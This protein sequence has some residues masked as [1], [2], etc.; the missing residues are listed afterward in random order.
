MFEP[1]LTVEEAYSLWGL[2][3]VTFE[4]FKDWWNDA[5][6]YCQATREFISLHMFCAEADQ[7]WCNL[8]WDRSCCLRRNRPQTSQNSPSIAPTGRAN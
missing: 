1:N 6:W 8:Q 3:C 7:D 2:Y 4:E 5:V